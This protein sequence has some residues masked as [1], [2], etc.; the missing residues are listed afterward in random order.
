MSVYR[1]LVGLALVLALVSGCSTPGP[2]PAPATGSSDREVLIATTTTTQDS[3]LLDVLLPAF[4]QAT[5]YSYR[6]II[7]GTGDALDLAAR[8]EADVVLSHAPESEKAWMAQGYGSSR[9]LVMYNDFAV[10]GPPSD[11]AG[12]RSATSAADA[13]RKIAEHGAP[14][15]S[16]GDQS[17][18]HVRE[19]ALW[20]LAG[21]D[22]KDQPW[23]VE[24]GAGQGQTLMAAD[25]RGACSLADR[26]TWSALMSRLK[27]SELYQGDPELL[28]FYHV[29]P[30]SNSRV[31]AVNT[32]G[33]QAFADYVL[34]AEGQQIIEAFGRDTYPDG[35]FHGASGKTEADF[36]VDR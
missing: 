29:M 4:K 8:G 5:G 27:L 26:G 32:A 36:G 23:Y 12:V 15:V 35:V 21:I 28:N 25:E 20:K 19:L 34:S 24:A 22:P 14:F 7:Q 17:G 3:G 2:T 1:S 6:T 18:T 30:V 11:P 31:A 10:V 33:G 9:D 16:R 13:L